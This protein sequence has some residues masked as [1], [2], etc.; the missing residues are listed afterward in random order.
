MWKILFFVTLAVIVAGAIFFKIDYS[1]SVR[2]FKPINDINP[3]GK[4]LGDTVQ[5]PIDNF[6]NQ[7]E[8]SLQKKSQNLIDA[9]GNQAYNQAQNTVN[10]IFDKSNSPPAV[11]VNILGASNAPPGSFVVD[12]LKDT[13][14]KLSL[15]KGIRYYL[16]FQN[17][18]SG[19][20]L[21]IDNNKYQ[22]SNNETI[23]LQ[24]SSNGTYPI[25]LNSCEINDKNLGELVV[26]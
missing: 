4:I 17:T 22:I 5:K 3:P 18:P 14:L 23:E 13:N 9:V 2:H 15:N 20:C 24:F 25:R 12:F 11:T 6:L 1:P 26:Q 19:Y 7:T 8:D 10:A 16:Q 21:Y